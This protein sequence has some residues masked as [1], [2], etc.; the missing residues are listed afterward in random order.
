M[1]E[2]SSEETI[3]FSGNLLAK[4]ILKYSQKDILLKIRWSIH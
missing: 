2:T 4:S 3:K 1:T